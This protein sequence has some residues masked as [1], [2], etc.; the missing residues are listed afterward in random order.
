MLLLFFFLRTSKACKIIN[1]GIFFSVPKHQWKKST[2]FF[3]KKSSEKNLWLQ[4]STKNWQIK[5]ASFFL[6]PRVELNYYFLS[7][8]KNNKKKCNVLHDIKSEKSGVL[9]FWSPIFFVTIRH[10]FATIL[11]WFNFTAPCVTS[12]VACALRYFTRRARVTP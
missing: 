11:W 9:R 7:L 2:E 1:I 6:W 10:C 3:T 4:L 8:Q 12:R 5:F